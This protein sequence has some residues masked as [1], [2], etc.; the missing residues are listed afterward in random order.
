M[1]SPYSVL[2]FKTCRKDSSW[3]PLGWY[4][5][6]TS[7]THIFLLRTH[8]LA[9]WRDKMIIQRGFSAD[10]RKKNFDKECYRIVLHMCSIDIHLNVFDWYSIWCIFSI[11][12]IL[13][14]ISELVPGKFVYI[15][16]QHVL[17]VRSHSNKFGL[18]VCQ[19]HKIAHT[20]FVIGSTN[21][22]QLH[23]IHTNCYGAYWRHLL[24]FLAEV[25]P[26]SPT[27][28]CYQINFSNKHSYHII[29]SFHL[30]TNLW[31]KVELPRR[32]ILDVVLRNE[33]TVKSPI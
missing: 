18:Q 2:I 21:I 24:M 32:A 28:A 19:K 22:C 12:C 8:S 31:V 15:V 3:D 16:I 25:L 4:F 13:I 14:L 1:I 11:I 29:L 20:G 7:L 5:I 27:Y 9:N 33:A 23:R 26:T 6:W 17:N 30:H 10:Q